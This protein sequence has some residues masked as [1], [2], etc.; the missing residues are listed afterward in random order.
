[1]GWYRYRKAVLCMTISFGLYWCMAELPVILRLRENSSMDDVEKFVSVLIHGGGYMQT[2]GVLLFVFSFCMCLNHVLC[3]LNSHIFVRW[4]SRKRYVFHC[5]KGVA[6]FSLLFVLIHEIIGL[7]GYLFSVPLSVLK[8]CNYFQNG[9]LS[10]VCMLLYFIQIGAAVLILQIFVKRKYIPVVMFLLQMTFYLLARLKIL[11]YVPC[12]NAAMAGRLVQGQITVNQV[13][14]I[15]IGNMIVLLLLF[16]V[17]YLLFMQK[18][19][20]E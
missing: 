1:M 10:G 4:E 19:I 6:A 9:I 20:R 15:W 7:T 17:F 18:D 12:K 5:M 2:L 13:Y 16:A 3:P 11:S 8:E 14:V